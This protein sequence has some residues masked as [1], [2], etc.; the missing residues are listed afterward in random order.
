MEKKISSKFLTTS[1]QNSSFKPSL[2]WLLFL[3]KNGEK[4]YD[5]DDHYIPFAIVDSLIGL[6][7]LFSFLCP[8]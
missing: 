1:T 5:G 3:E 4:P 2:W 6:V 8:F 7:M